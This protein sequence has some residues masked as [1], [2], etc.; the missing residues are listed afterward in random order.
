[1]VRVRCEQTDSR[2]VG[3]TD[4]QTGRQGDSYIPQ[5]LFAGEG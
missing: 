2:T 3:R 4:T 1:M 5:N